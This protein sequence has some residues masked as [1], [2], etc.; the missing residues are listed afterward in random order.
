MTIGMLV[1]SLAGKA[2]AM[3]GVFQDGTPFRFADDSEDGVSGTRAVDY[4]GEQLL[5]AGY[6]YSGNESKRPG[7]VRGEPA[8]RHTDAFPQPCTAA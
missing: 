7:P 5:K 4:F 8:L 3:H 6:A 1:E 2:G